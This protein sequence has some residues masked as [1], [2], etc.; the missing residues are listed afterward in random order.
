M[1]HF[2]NAITMKD[3]FKDEDLYNWGE[4]I[5][6][7]GDVIE[8]LFEEGSILLIKGKVKTSLRKNIHSVEVSFN[9]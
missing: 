3:Y 6:K 8:C 9:K 5:C 7:N 4:N 2:L 1:A